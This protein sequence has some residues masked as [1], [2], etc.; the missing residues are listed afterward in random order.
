MFH[1]RHAARHPEPALT[2]RVRQ[3]TGDGV[4]TGGFRG[5]YVVTL[6]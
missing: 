3:D 2:G 1:I 6:L 5:R 4:P